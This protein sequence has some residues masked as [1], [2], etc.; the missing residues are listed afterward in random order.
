LAPNSSEWSVASTSVPKYQQRPYQWPQ[1]HED[2]KFAFPQLLVPS[3]QSLKTESKSARQYGRESIQ[4]SGYHPLTYL[5]PIPPLIP[6]STGASPSPTFHSNIRLSKIS[7]PELNNQ[8]LHSR[9]NS[10]PDCAPSKGPPR[11]SS[12]FRYN[13]DTAD[14]SGIGGSL[15]NSSQC[16]P[17]V[18]THSSSNCFPTLMESPLPQTTKPDELRSTSVICFAH[19]PS[20]STAPSTK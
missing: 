3:N 17:H 2:H 14:G 20:S 19:R 7:T 13:E 12:R 15:D 10:L 11:K 1:P 8:H 18:T 5:R 16:L 6:V 4:Q 9:S